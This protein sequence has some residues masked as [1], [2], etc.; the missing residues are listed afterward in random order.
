[1]KLLAASTVTL[2]CIATTAGTP[3][4]ISAGPIPEKT[5]WPATTADLQA[6]NTASRT[7]ASTSRLLISRALTQCG[8]LLRASNA[9]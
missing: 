3:A 9:R 7:P 1:M 8:R 2:N 5:L 6:V 4:W